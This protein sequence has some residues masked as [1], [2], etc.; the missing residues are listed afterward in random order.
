MSKIAALFL[1]GFLAMGA[2]TAQAPE[3][4]PSLALAE[5]PV[6]LFPNA[7]GFYASSMPSYGLHYQRWLYPF[8]FQVTAGG[9]ATDSPYS[10][11]IKDWQ[12]T[13]QV[14]AALALDQ[15]V[16][17]SWFAHLLYVFATAGENVESL[18]Y[19]SDPDPLFTGDETYAPGPVDASFKAGVGVG[20]E[21]IL[22]KHFSI[23]L[24]F[25]YVGDPVA[26]TVNF[27][28]GGALRYRF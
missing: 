12:A 6:A 28:L 25:G 2:G 22:F 5:A 15:R 7:L 14:S 23:P 9:Y 4:A 3:P 8:G 21:F 27:M 20:I 10:A 24:E 19:L 26:G 1:A 18:A 13:A 17:S 11:P 16:Y